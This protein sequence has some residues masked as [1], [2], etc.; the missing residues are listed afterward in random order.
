M[1]SFE[2]TVHSCYA[3]EI[4]EL[5]RKRSPNGVVA[6]EQRRWL[7]LRRFDIR[8]PAES[9]KLLEEDYRQWCWDRTLDEAW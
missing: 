2:I 5:I 6:D 1:A 8:G 3:R 9:V 7:F 4:R